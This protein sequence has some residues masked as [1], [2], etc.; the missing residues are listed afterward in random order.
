MNPGPPN[1][2]ETLFPLC[3]WAYPKVNIIA[4]VEFLLAYFEVVLQP[5]LYRDYSLGILIVARLKYA[6]QAA[7]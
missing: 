4:W 7:K 5:L 2:W 6:T 1:H 3:Q